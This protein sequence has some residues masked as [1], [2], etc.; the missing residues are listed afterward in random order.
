MKAWHFLRNDSRL[1]WGPHGE[2]PGPYVKV[3]QTVTV[4]PPVIMCRKGLHASAHVYDALQY[5]PG[6]LVCHVELSGEIVKGPDKIVASARTILWQADATNLLLKFSCW[7][8]ERALRQEK[9]KDERCWNVIH[10]RRAWMKGDATDADL[11]VAQAAALEAAR[12]ATAS[13]ALPAAAQAMRAVARS[14]AMW[15]AAASAKLAPTPP[16]TGWY[17]ARAFASC[18]TAWSDAEERIQRRELQKRINGLV[19]Q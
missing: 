10:T 8:A 12:S 7:C 4:R 16:G 15:A 14:R 17:M 1:R 13:T 18:Y 2:C 5:A 6:A 11:A 9:I 3:G 19:P